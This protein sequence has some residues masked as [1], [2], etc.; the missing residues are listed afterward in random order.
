MKLDLSPF[1]NALQSLDK[2]LKEYKKNSNEFMRDACIQRFEYCYELSWKMLKRFLETTSP[3]INLI[4]EL[5]FPDLIRVSNEKN[6]LRSDWEKWKI[7]RD[8]RNATSH[9]YNEKKAKE[10]FSVIPD[11]YLEAE[12]LLNNLKKGNEHL[13]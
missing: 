8:A 9:A 1:E 10:V 5:S 12:F 3:G 13:E 6:L 4:D 11:F 7:Y 2:V